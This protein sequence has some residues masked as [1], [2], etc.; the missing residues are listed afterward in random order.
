MGMRVYI[1]SVIIMALRI[2]NIATPKTLVVKSTMLP[3]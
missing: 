3:Q 2:A 1:R